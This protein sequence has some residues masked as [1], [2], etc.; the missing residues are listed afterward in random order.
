MSNRKTI[1]TIC[2]AIFLAI[3]SIST[4]LYYINTFRSSENIRKI[5]IFSGVEKADYQYTANLIPNNIYNKTQIVD[6]E[7]VYTR[8]VKNISIDFN[9]NASFDKIGNISVEYSYYINLISP[10]KWTKVVYESKVSKLD[11]N[12]SYINIPMHFNIEPDKYFSMVKEIVS[13]TGASYGKILIKIVP[14]IKLSFVDNELNTLKDVMIPKFQMTFTRNTEKG[15]IISF[16]GFKYGKKIP[17]YRN[18]V[19]SNGE[20]PAYIYLNLGAMIFSLGGVIS[21]G[22][23]YSRSFG[24]SL[25]RRKRSLLASIHRFIKENEDIII[26]TDDNISPINGEYTIVSL[27]SKDD[28]IRLSEILDKPV[29]YF[30]NNDGKHV[31]TILEENILYQYIA[32]V[33]G[34]DIEEKNSA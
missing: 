1:I 10:N 5:Y 24:I 17:V 3:F 28:L 25:F 16:D 2:L 6:D 14:S 18:V 13:E 21:T 33:K 32:E 27:L 8:L 23:F 19:E 34:E 30:N 9:Y 26:K 4:S 11:I 12:G 22:Y 31:F 15:D 29:M 20:N 7:F